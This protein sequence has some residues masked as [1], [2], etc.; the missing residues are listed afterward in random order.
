MLQSMGLQTVRHKLVTEQQQLIYVKW[1]NNRDLLY[2]TGNYIQYLVLT[3]NGKESK[4]IEALL[5]DTGNHPNRRACTG[6]G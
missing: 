1:I 6:L 3:Y 5:K 2:S 4:S